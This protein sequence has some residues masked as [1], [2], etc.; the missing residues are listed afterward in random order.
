MS[1]H[2]LALAPA[3]RAAIVALIALIARLKLHPFV[4]LVGVDHNDT[5]ITGGVFNWLEA[6][7]VSRLRDAERALRRQKRDVAREVA[8]DTPHGRLQPAVD[9]PVV[10]A[11]RARR[12]G[13]RDR[14]HELRERRR[15]RNRVGRRRCHAP[16][17]P[18]EVDLHV[19][20]GGEARGVTRVQRVAALLAHRLVLEPR[21]RVQGADGTRVVEDVLRQVAVPIDL[22]RPS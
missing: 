11:E 6:I 9:E 17:A 13:Q 1:C 21:A 3:T 18:V 20:A 8:V 4:A 7:A 10:H 16:D 5:F 19:V 15:D 2:T 14:D 22:P 12:V